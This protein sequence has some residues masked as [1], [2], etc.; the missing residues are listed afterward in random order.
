MPTRFALLLA[1]CLVVGFGGSQ[2]FAQSDFDDDG[3]S[4]GTR[5]LEFEPVQSPTHPICK[6]KIRGLAAPVPGATRATG[7]LDEISFTFAVDGSKQPQDF[8]V[9]ANIGGAA[10]VNWGIPVIKEFGIGM[11]LGTGVTSSA[12]AVRVYELLGESTGRTQ[13]FTTVGLFQ[14]TDSGFAWGFAHD[15]LYQK[16][17]DTFQ[18]GQWRIR[19]SYTLS[20]SHEIG[21]TSSLNSYSDKGVFGAS[22]PVMLSP[23]EQGSMYYRRFWGT[24]AQTTAWIGIAD[25]HGENNAVTGP[26]P[27]KHVPFLFGADVLMPLTTSLAIYGET[28]MITPSDTG[29]VDAYLGVQWFPGGRAYRA[30]RG[31]YSPLM[32]LAA[33]TSF[34]V[35]LSQ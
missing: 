3:N 20:S 5:P 13:S 14:R 17:F 21:I 6:N 18:L 24:G 4:E 10:S 32:P 2:V 26:S 30:R 35:D 33:P 16:S 28:N 27:P 19:G 1:T 12:N 34:A 7:L 15:F 25:K 23:I 29:T 8:G 22:T 31:R 9:N 11:Q